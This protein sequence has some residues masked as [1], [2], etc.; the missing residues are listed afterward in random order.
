MIRFSKL[1]LGVSMAVFC[2]LPVLSACQSNASRVLS[3]KS[4]ARPTDIIVGIA[5]TA[6]SC[7]FASGDP[8]FAAYRLADEVNSY[9]GRPRLLLVPRNDPS[10]LPA[11][12][13]QAETKGSTASGTFSDV[14]AYGPLLSSPQASRITADV[15]RWTTGGTSCA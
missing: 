7:W 6:Q 15:R 13:I 3:L 1:V 12:V 5:K 14:Q 4:E 8:A 10:A 2:A 9:S 11:L